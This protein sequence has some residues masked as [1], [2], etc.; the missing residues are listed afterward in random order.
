MEN[1]NNTK[2]NIVVFKLGG[3]SQNIIA[4]NNLKTIIEEIYKNNKIFIVVS[5][6][7]GI[8][9]IL[10]NFEGEILDNNH[11]CCL[12]IIKKHTEFIKTLNFD[13]N[14]ERQTIQQI[15]Y[16]IN[17]IFKSNKHNYN[18]D[19]WKRQRIVL[20]EQLSSLI[21][22]KFLNYNN[23]KSNNLLATD[24]IYFTHQSKNL[25]T[26]KV[27]SE[28][29]L[30]EFNRNNIIITQGFTARDFQD[31]VT[32]LMG[33]GSS[34][35]SGAIFASFLNASEYQIWTD[36]AGIY[37]ID[38][39]LC[40]EAKMIVQLNYEIAQE[41]AGMGAKIIHPYC[42]KP[43][44]KD[45]IPITIRN[46]FNLKDPITIIN[47]EKNNTHAYSIQK[48][49]I[50]FKIKSINMWHGV[51]FASDIFETFKKYN[52]DID[53]ITTSQFEITIT[54][55]KEDNEEGIN[56]TIDNLRC[57]YN[58]EIFDNYNLVSIVNQNIL[59]SD[60]INKIHSISS[61]YDILLESISSNNYSISFAIKEDPY[62]LL[63]DLYKN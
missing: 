52:I 2:S 5:A 47:N 32:V 4:Y 41:M 7:S 49:I 57:K 10:L 39:R 13:E 61:K 26:L 55:K 58:V 20:G 44:Q 19:V 21:L 36:V 50:I 25:N 63:L 40:K 48:N 8:T 33:R 3:T 1:T 24:I 59:K 38:P 16:M 62:D 14:F 28:T 35:T 17:Y 53:I 6:I 56:E 12:K 29:I 15:E 34:D 46:S 11:K 23:F 45:N 31:N 18:T 51:G 37:D 30:E 22:N 9:N 54:I 60:R 43:C 42:I 27:N